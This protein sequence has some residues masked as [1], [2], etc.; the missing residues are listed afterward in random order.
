M[1][2]CDF[3]AFLEHYGWPANKGHMPFCIGHRG[4]SGRERENTL[5]AFPPG[6]AELGAEMWELDTQITK[7]GVVVVSP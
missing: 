4:A 5:A 1:R 3:S 2:R 6:A 7:D